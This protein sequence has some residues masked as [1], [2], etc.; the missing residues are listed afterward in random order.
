MVS[1]TQVNLDLLLVLGLGYAAIQLRSELFGLTSHPVEKADL[2]SSFPSDPFGEVVDL[3]CRPQYS[4][5][6]DKHIAYFGAL[7]YQS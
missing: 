4:S 5:Q 3:A 1:S 6:A 2:T 7:H